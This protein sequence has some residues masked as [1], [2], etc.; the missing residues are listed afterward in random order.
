[1]YNIHAK[2]IFPSDT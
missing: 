2:T 1:M